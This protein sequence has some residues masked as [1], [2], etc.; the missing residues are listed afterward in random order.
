[1]PSCQQAADKTAQ[2]CAPSHA[3]HRCHHSCSA[4]RV[5]ETVRYPSKCLCVHTCWLLHKAC[6]AAGL[7]TRYHTVRRG[8]EQSPTH[9]T[10]QPR[11]PSSSK[12]QQQMIPLQQV[13]G[14]VAGRGCTCVVLLPRTLT[15]Q[16]GGLA[17][18]HGLIPVYVY[19]AVVTQEP[20]RMPPAAPLHQRAGPAAH[21][22]HVPDALST[23]GSSLSPAACSARY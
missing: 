1:M 8:V 5:S 16:C 13:H 2:T 21:M 11:L 22:P 18:W 17:G 23:D 20:T 4:A 6:P 19:G 3:T 9:H 14:G 10:L 15:P 12:T 7:H